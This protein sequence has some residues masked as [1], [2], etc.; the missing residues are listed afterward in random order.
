MTLTER[1][2]PDPARWITGRISFPSSMLDR[3]TPATTPDERDLMESDMRTAREPHPAVRPSHH[4][5][6]FTRH[7]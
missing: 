6:V 1:R 4:E 5:E 7:G 2:A 3:V